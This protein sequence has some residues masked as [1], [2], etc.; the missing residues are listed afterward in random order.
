MRCGSRAG[1][2]NNAV[3]APD[4]RCVSAE[5][6]KRSLKSGAQAHNLSGTAS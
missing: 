2:L 6:F 1:A 4:D 5:G 3:G